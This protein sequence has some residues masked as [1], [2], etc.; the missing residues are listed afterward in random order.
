MLKFFLVDHL[1]YEN[2]W[3]SLRNK[4]R[5]F[6]FFGTPYCPPPTSFQKHITLDAITINF[7]LLLNTLVIGPSDLGK[8]FLWCSDTHWDC[9]LSRSVFW[10][11]D[12]TSISGTL[13]SWIFLLSPYVEWLCTLRHSSILG[14]QNHDS[15]RHCPRCVP[16]KS[17]I[18]YYENLKVP[19]PVSKSN[20]IQSKSLSLLQDVTKKVPD[21]IKKKSNIGPVYA[22][23]AVERCNCR[24]NLK[25]AS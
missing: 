18:F 16:W 10:S 20:L 5:T 14:I 21:M 4:I 24:A 23:L 7:P 1:T 13:L 17:E 8:Y 12:F 9:S 25:W 3:V 15:Y 6:G 11:I 22:I 19:V 2:Q